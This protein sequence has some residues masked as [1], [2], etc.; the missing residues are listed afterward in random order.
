MILSFP[1][2]HALRMK[3]ATVALGGLVLTAGHAIAKNHDLQPFTL[4]QSIPRSSRSRAWARHSAR[5][6]DAEPFIVLSIG[7][8]ARPGSA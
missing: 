3:I 1:A 6:N 4:V 5:R 7:T 8:G 2:L